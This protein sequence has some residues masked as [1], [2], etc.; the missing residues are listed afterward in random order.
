M[1][2]KQALAEVKAQAQLEADMRAIDE[3]APKIAEAIGKRMSP[4]GTLGLPPLLDERRLRYGM[5]DAVFAAQAAY[6]RI[7]LFQ[8]DP[9][10]SDGEKY[11]DTGIYMPDSA[12]RRV[13]EEAPRGVIV[14]AGLRALDSLRS[15]GMDLGHIVSFVRL[16]PW[17]LPVDMIAGAPVYVLILRDSDIVGSEDTAAALRAG[18]LVI[19]AKPDHSYIGRGVPSL[20]KIGDDY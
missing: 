4:P 18:G 19:E 17:R 6:D 20:P 13:R 5:C 2:V 9:S 11:G 12:K 15:N 14:S 8:I 3:A 7:L 10:F 1:N 16:S